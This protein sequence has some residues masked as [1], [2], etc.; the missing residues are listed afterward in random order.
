MLSNANCKVKL[1]HQE[2]RLAHK[3]L[4]RWA[5]CRLSQRD[6]LFGL[7]IFRGL[8]SVEIDASGKA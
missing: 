7:R 2:M 1:E 4:S 6:H 5:I 3:G 8:D